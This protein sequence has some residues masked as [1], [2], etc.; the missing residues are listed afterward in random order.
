MGR[1]IMS[2]S[3]KKFWDNPRFTQ[4]P[5]KEQLKVLTF[6][7]VTIIVFFA[8]VAALFL[9]FLF[10]MDPGDTIP[11]HIAFFI[12]IAIFVYGLYSLAGMFIDTHIKRADV[13]RRIAK[14]SS[15][16]HDTQH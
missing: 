7:L 16:T 8:I 15:E 5:A 4:Q 12:G 2:K 11:L 6:T 10:S 9:L 3:S 13:M 14:E 1:Y